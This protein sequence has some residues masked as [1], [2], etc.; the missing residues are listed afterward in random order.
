MHNAQPYDVRCQVC[1]KCLEFNCSILFLHVLAF[2][3]CNQFYVAF[4]HAI[5]DRVRIFRGWLDLQR[6]KKQTFESGL[7]E[8]HFSQLFISNKDTHMGFCA[9]D[10]SHNERRHKKWLE[11]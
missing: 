4:P 8:W 11:E 7:F 10:R 5:C 3:A 1:K 6:E 9:Y 2:C